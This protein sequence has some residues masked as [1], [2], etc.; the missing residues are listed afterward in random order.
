MILRFEYACGNM[1][2]GSRDVA[3]LIHC[4]DFRATNAL[5]LWDVFRVLLSNQGERWLYGAARQDARFLR[6]DTK[7]TVVIQTQVVQLEDS[8][9]FDDKRFAHG[10]VGTQAATHAGQEDGG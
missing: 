3:G 2:D 1:N 4:M 5:F 9:S 6:H 10:Y 8:F 7:A